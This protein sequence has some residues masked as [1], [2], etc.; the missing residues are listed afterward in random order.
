MKDSLERLFN[1]KVTFGLILVVFATLFLFL[2]NLSEQF[3][4]P[5]F[6]VISIL[7]GVLTLITLARFL[8]SKSTTLFITPL[9]LPFTLLIIVAII[10]TFTST[11]HYV[12]IFG[13]HPLI[14]GSLVSLLVYVLLY[15]VT[16][17]NLKSF[18]QV[19][20]LIASLLVGGF[21]LSTLSLL[22]FFGIKVFPFE[23]TQVQQFTPTGST[24]STA[25]ILTLLLP[26]PLLGIFS[27]SR[28]NVK[29]F[30]FIILTL[31]A[32]TIILI[33]TT[34][35]IL[36][37]IA[38][39]LVTLAS[40]TYTKPLKT[41]PFF[42]ASLLIVSVVAILCF[43]PGVGDFKNPISTQFKSFPREPQLP[44]GTSW[45]ISI[46]S[47]RDQPLWGTGPG[48]YTFNFTQYKPVEF[49]STELW[50][51]RFAKSF[52]EYFQILS[53][54]GAAGFMLF[55][56]ITFLVI[57]RAYTV[58]KVE[59]S[60][61]NSDIFKKGL[62]IASISFFLLL[63][64]NPS[65]LV[66]WVIGVII[67]A[68]FMVSYNFYQKV[69]LRF[70]AVKAG[71]E[72]VD[73][74]P[75][76]LSLLVIPLLIYGS[77]QMWTFVRADYHSRIAANIFHSNGNFGEVYD[78]LI[79]AR[80]IAPMNDLYRSSLAD[81]SLSIA[82]QIVLQKGPKEDSPNGNFSE[83]DKVA[84]QELLQQS[85]NEATVATQLSPK[86]AV[87][88]EALASIYRQISGVATNDQNIFLQTLNAYGRAIQQDPLNPLTRINVGT[89]YYSVKN[90]DMAIRFFND[91][92]NLKQDYPLAFFN[93][94]IALKD[95]GDLNSAQQ[96]AEKA[97]SLVNTQH[98]DYK[99]VSE[100][101]D[102]LKSRIASGSAQVSTAQPKD[103][104]EKSGL[105]KKNL[106]KVLDVEKPS[107]ISTP[108]AAPKE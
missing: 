78:N 98:P 69:D 5:K 4:L 15:F 32:T 63:L 35:T 46:S 101:L 107:K 2:N 71:G 1:T 8:L 43:I 88:W 27:P 3:E 56:I 9:H 29:V 65:T 33:S 81:I 24:F 61:E 95:K 20:Y 86:N 62:A 73:V 102:D 36:A 77:M 82:K 90:Y 6:I 74:F 94:S 21:F 10:S 108:E 91:A 47:F 48:T 66:I 13:N 31:F 55:I 97:L 42:T 18:A 19:Q 45:K 100:Y 23:W 51:F 22:S 25:A 54:L 41:V 11:S 64:T 30:F 60:E 44:F 67:I 103:T 93:L 50:N 106:P 34:P 7:V 79:A 87:H 99:I 52:N 92:A 12:G 70:G 17:N 89:L 37:M 39:V 75:L 83:E 104:V 84:I 58:L 28:M 68:S 40:A 57:L 26:F 85:I 96:A 14:H 53:T 49:N 16:V 72:S 105:E 38:T 59:R 76:M 80:D